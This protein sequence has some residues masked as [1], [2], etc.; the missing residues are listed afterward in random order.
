MILSAQKLRLESLR[1]P[2][3]SMIH[4]KV[5]VKPDLTFMGSAGLTVSDWVEVEHDFSPGVNSGGDVG[6][7]T[8]ILENFSN[9]KY[10]LDGHTEKLIPVR[11]LT[12]I[13]M[14]F[15]REKAKLIT[16]SVEAEQPS[17]GKICNVTVF[18]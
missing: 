2:V 1:V 8:S 5:E 13:P 15:R 9:V 6:I 18:I 12:C 11:R 14:P 16:R 7:I 17:E 4:P 3:T 10:I